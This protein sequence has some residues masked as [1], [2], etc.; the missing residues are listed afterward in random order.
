MN[1]LIQKLAVF[2]I[3]KGYLTCSFKEILIHSAKW[4]V[5]LYIYARY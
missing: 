5:L 1:L 2:Y 3:K 4:F